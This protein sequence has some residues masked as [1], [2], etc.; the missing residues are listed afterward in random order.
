MEGANLCPIH[1]GH[2][3]CMLSRWGGRRSIAHIFSALGGQSR[4]RRD[5]QPGN[6][7]MIRVIQLAIQIGTSSS[8][9]K[10]RVHSPSRRVLSIHRH[11]QQLSSSHRTSSALVNTRCLTSNVCTLPRTHHS[12][13]PDYPLGAC[14][15]SSV[16]TACAPTNIPT[17]ASLR[18]G[19]P[20]SRRITDR[21][22]H[23]TGARSHGIPA[24]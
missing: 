14:L 5:E 9:L 15:T 7:C 12:N 3:I 20:P 13:Q 23:L 11:I 22:I 6:G 19:Y 8:S 10:Y 2:Y 1:G 24:H 18:P 17:A 21:T 4:S 16:P